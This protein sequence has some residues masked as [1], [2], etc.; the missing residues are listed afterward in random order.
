MRQIY[1]EDIDCCSTDRRTPNKHRSVPLE[2]V[3]PIVLAGMKQPDNLTRL[4]IHPSNIRS[5]VVVTCETREREIPQFVTAVM[6]AGNDVIDL[7]GQHVML[8]RHPAVLA[9]RTCPLPHLIDE[10]LLH[11][12][13]KY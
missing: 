6:F 2:M 7:K 10:H 9:E 11:S 5:F 4:G 13:L 12:S 8:L 3:F 1:G